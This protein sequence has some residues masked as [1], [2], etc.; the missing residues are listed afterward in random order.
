MQSSSAISS[1]LPKYLRVW[2]ILSLSVVLLIIMSAFLSRSLE[3]LNEGAAWVAHTERVRFQLAR[4]LQSCSDLGN[5]V[6]GYEITHDESLF[7]PAKTAESLIPVELNDLQSL[8]ADDAAQQ[9]LFAQL[10][11]LTHQRQLQT[12]AQRERALHRDVA[13]V[14][15]EISSGEAKRQMDAVRAVIAQMQAEER[16]LLDFHTKA[17]RSAYNA[18]AIAIW[19]AA[20]LAIGLLISITVLTL[21]DAERLRLVQEELATTLRSVGDAV[22]STDAAGVVRFMN[23]VAEQLTGWTNATARGRPLEDVFDVINE[24]TRA[25]VETPLAQVL[26][27]KKIVALAN[28]TVLRARDGTERPIEDSG[29]PILD[30]SGEITG[31]VL[32]FRDATTDRAARRALVESR[33]ALREADNRKDIFLATLSHELRNPLAPIRTATRVLETPNLSAADLERSRSIIARQVRHMASLLDDL[34]DISRITRGVLTLKTETVEL[35]ALMEAAIE[36]AQ[37]AIAAKGHTFEVQWP[38]E[39]IGLTADP[40]R[41]TQVIANLLTNAA[42]YTD[43]GGHITLG[44]RLDASGIEIF[45]RDDGIGIAKE[46]QPRVFD[47]F[48]QIDTSHEHSEGGIGIG[49]ALVKGFVELHGGSV[50]VHSA[51]MNQGSEFVVHLPI[52][53]RTEPP[54]AAATTPA[55]TV[56]TARRVLIADDNRDGAEIMAMLLTHSGYDVQLA[57]TGPDA[58]DVAAQQR[59]DV[60]ILDIGMPGMSGYDVARRIRSQPWGGG[61]MLIAVTGWGQEDDKR[62]AKEAGFDHHLT[63]PI[64][65]GALE[66]LMSPASEVT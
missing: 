18:V 32:V 50:E 12:E 56:N 34:L 54:V 51:G 7:E 58:V 44:A 66:R 5:G 48:S 22:I 46:M 60:A 31:A 42:K 41:L 28:H 17:T 29:A 55:T 11:E 33:D 15:A 27:E 10:V 19:V 14:Q 61:M 35:K 63:K 45:V 59:P 8:L 57:H 20:A 2:V 37:P 36:T 65:P 1:Y 24:Q 62:K 53:L 52:A 9:P 3:T 38:G 64:D 13:G 16:H 49:L 4:I 25:P 23:A 40:L 39:R 21:R 47:M 26:R 30:P 43:P 6:A